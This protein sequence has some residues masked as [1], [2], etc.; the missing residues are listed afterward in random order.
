[1]RSLV[2]LLLICALTAPSASAQGGLTSFK[3]RAEKPFTPTPVLLDLYSGNGE[4]G[5]NDAEVRALQGPFGGFIGGPSPADFAAAR[6]AGPAA[7]LSNAPWSTVGL[8]SHPQAKWIGPDQA[9]GQGSNQSSVLFA[10][11]FEVPTEI[12]GSAYLDLV[13][14]ADETLGDFGVAGVFINEQPVKDTTVI[15]SDDQQNIF[16]T[17][18]V[19]KLL[20]PGT[21]WMYFYNINAAFFG[22]LMFHARLRVNLP[23]PD[24][25]V[26]AIPAYIGVQPGNNAGSF[27]SGAN[28]PGC[29][30]NFDRWYYFVPPSS[31][32]FT[33][34]VEPQPESPI[35]PSLGVYTGDCGALNQIGC[36]Q[37]LPQIPGPE[38]TP[39]TYIGQATAGEP[40]LLRVGGAIGTRG[41]Y[42]LTIDVES[43]LD[44]LVYP[45][46]GHLYKITP[47]LMDIPTARTWAAQAGGY[48]AAVNDEAEND[49]I[50]NNLASN[51]QVWLG[52]S[53]EITEGV[54]L[55]DS[56]EPF[57]FDSWN[58][59]EP[60]DFALCGGEDYVEMEGGGLWN[61]L[62]TGLNPCANHIRRGLVEIPTSGLAAVSTVG[63]ACAPKSITP[64]LVSEPHQLGSTVDMGI[65][66]GVPM[67]PYVVFRSPFPAM[68][69]PSGDCVIHVDQLLL[70]VMFTGTLGTYGSA[71]FEFSVPNLPSLIGVR[72][73]WQAEILSPLSG[74]YFTNGL[75]VLLGN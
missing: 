61:D 15:F 66:G 47:T 22:G 56:G 48:L 42:T 20:R 73:A 28:P 16:G 68:P 43:Q 19:G 31:G 14:S 45:A 54:W 9:Y 58:A 11:P 59:T 71:S 52:L 23:R 12:V 69:N 49:W 26:D 57:T 64:E 63:G 40:I 46:N 41:P 38:A 17:R 39:A 10:V 37:G 1:M 35:V 13:F 18:A 62:N 53:D 7:I 6:N 8:E 60:N 21:N 36:Q 33:A 25:C 34:S 29:V 24:E 32:V 74:S 27:T 72:E 55:W 2:G 65:V 70:E 30:V 4:P 67:D 50:Q 44:G 75:E 5:G 3:Q 51:L